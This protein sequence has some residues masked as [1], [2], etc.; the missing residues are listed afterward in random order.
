MSIRGSGLALSELAAA[1][2]PFLFDLWHN[3]DVMRYADEFPW[4]RGW[5][6]SDDADEAW[7]LYQERRGELGRA[8]TQLI[9]W[10]GDSRIGEAFV[11]PLREGYTFGRWGKPDGVRCVMG[12][13]KLMPQLWG[14]GLGTRGMR[15]VVE[16]VFG[17]TSCALFVVPPHRHNPA[18]ERVYEKAGFVRFMGMRS[19]RN[20][21]VMELTRERFEELYCQ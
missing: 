18:A 21:R 16:W 19:W 8:Y 4:L 3:P 17:Q 12:D 1:D 13:I 6:K 11:S 20:H 2:L 9:L 14:H 5:S 10:L 7:R 15:R